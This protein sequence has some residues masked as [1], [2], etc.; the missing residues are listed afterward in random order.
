[1][2]KKVNHLL[3][4]WLYGLPV[5]PKLSEIYGL[6]SSSHPVPAANT[7]SPKDISRVFEKEIL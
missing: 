6:F 7:N 2:A 1:L 5:Q 3:T 4:T